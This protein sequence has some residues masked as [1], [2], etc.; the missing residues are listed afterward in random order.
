M[1]R[2]LL[3][4]LLVETGRVVSVDRLI[5][6]LWNDRPPESA[7]KIVQGLV[8][9]LRRAVGRATIVRRAGGYLVPREAGQVDVRRFESLLAE[10]RAAPPQRASALFGE[11]L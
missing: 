4:L 7:E 8:S 6:A 5:D 11:A 9:H 3:A 1:A 2:A 10:G